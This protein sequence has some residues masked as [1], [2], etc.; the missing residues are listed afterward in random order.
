MSETPRIEVI[1]GLDVGEKRIGLALARGDVRI[2]HPLTTLVNDAD[3]EAELKQ[4]I[5]REQITRLVVG[6]PRNLSGQSTAQTTIAEAFADSLGKTTG[7]PVIL[8]DE[9]L[10]SVKAED[11][12]RSRGKPYDKGDVDALAATYIL[13]D[14]L[15][16]AHV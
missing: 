2:S 14:Y 16:A 13:Q 7:L 6:L 1:L 12:L 15:E 5:A 4:I 10:T 8:Q 11:E 3:V 9:A